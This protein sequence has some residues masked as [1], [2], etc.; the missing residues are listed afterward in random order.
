MSFSQTYRIENKIEIGISFNNVE[1][2]FTKA[3]TL[4][5]IHMSS[6]A[7]LGL[8]MLYCQL[9]DN[10]KFSSN[11]AAQLVEGA[12][13]ELYLKPRSASAEVF[14][15]RIN[16]LTIKR[17]QSGDYITFDAYLDKPKWWIQTTN[18]VFSNQQ[19]TKVLESLA[20]SA[21]L[22]FS[23][24]LTNDTQNWYG[25]NYR[26]HDFAKRVARAGY[27][28]DFSFMQL[29]T[30]F[31]GELRYF[32]LEKMGVPAQRFTLLEVQPGLIPAVSF[33]PKNLGG[34]PNRES[35][36]KDLLL[37]QNP[38]D[39]ILYKA[40][41]G[42]AVDVNEKGK[43]NLSEDVKTSLVQATHKVGPI[44]YGNVT[45]NY[46]RAQ[47]QN[48][49]IADLFSQ[50]LDLVTPVP[51]LSLDL[52]LLDTVEVVAKSQLEE[53]AG[54]YR[55]ASK[56]IYVKSSEYYEKFELV[57]RSVSSVQPLALR[58]NLDNFNGSEETL[59][60]DASV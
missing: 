11:N 48:K 55:I 52:D 60:G 14:K 46:K 25:S 1:F 28:N 3:S 47:Y 44:N 2:P 16:S 43:L 31:S 4:G 13:V 33:Q 39:D 30:T 50:G 45:E 5:V 56:S 15:F 6:S 32:N 20:A 51:S 24:D 26:V 21:E 9:A 41:K 34:I 35:A 23:G 40:Q 58:S 54:L 37:E 7:K 57:R 22:T 19:S 27:V 18:E 42:I 29:A 10:I 49:R 17:E 38:L 53:F 36:Y 12:L 8:P 59:Y